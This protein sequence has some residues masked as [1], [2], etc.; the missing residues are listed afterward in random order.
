[1]SSTSKSGRPSH[2]VALRL[3]SFLGAP[4]G[5]RDVVFGVEEP[6]LAEAVMEPYGGLDQLRSSGGART[7]T[8]NSLLV[9]LTLGLHAGHVDRML[10]SNLL[11]LGGTRGISLQ[12]YGVLYSIFQ[13]VETPVHICT[14][15]P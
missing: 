6:A 5:L 4:S 15:E 14:F 2:T 12:G 3:L 1:M 9:G 10:E 11:A 7:S 13:C 8:M